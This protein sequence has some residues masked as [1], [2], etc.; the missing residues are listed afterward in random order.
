MHLSLLACL[1]IDLVDLGEDRD[2][3]FRYVLVYVEL[4]TRHVWLRPLT[5]KEALLVVREVRH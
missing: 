3:E 2:P 5:S 4:F 1:Q